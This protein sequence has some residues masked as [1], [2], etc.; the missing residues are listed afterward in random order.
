M[1]F[2]ITPPTAPA[3]PGQPGVAAAPG[4]AAD[5]FEA[6]LAEYAGAAGIQVSAQ[7]PAVSSNPAAAPAQVATEA[8]PATDEA[9]ASPNDQAAGTGVEPAQPWP[10]ITQPFA[11]APPVSAEAPADAL[12]G[13]VQTPPGLGKAA[14]R[15]EMLLAEAGASPP[16]GLQQ[17][18]AHLAEAG[19]PQGAAT[20]GEASEA[21]V[22]AAPTS[23]AQ[24]DADVRTA[25]PTAHAP[26]EPAS[27]AQPAVRAEPGQPGQPAVPA[28]PAIPAASAQVAQ[29]TRPASQAPS[30][31]LPVDAAPPPTASDASLVQPAPLDREAPAADP[32]APA[33]PAEPA[34]VAAQPLLQAAVVRARPIETAAAL[35]AAAE[36]T[37]PA[38]ELPTDDEPT[39][40]TPA[41]TPSQLPAAPGRRRASA[42]GETG[43]PK[44]EPAMTAAA[45]PTAADDPGPVHA[46]RS[47]PTT[48]ETAPPVQ[49]AAAAA[50]EALAAIDKPETPRA[51]EAAAGA[52]PGQASAEVPAQRDL[53]PGIR[54]A[55]DTVA[56][57]AADIARKLEG[58]STRFEVE[59]QPAGL[60]RVDVRIEIGA[61]GKLTAAFA[62]DSPQAAAE[63]RSRAPELQRALEQAGFDLSGGLSFDLADSSRF[64]RDPE[65]RQDGGAFRG[66]AFAQALATGEAADQAALPPKLSRR[67]SAA[68]DIRI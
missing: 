22:P 16:P 17:A 55:P 4:Q 34:P 48:A 45:S 33:K 28:T 40:A 31:S 68:L 6:L 66:R 46:A 30:R 12:A 3:S 25:R 13:Q 54:G 8:E 58:R 24:S 49:G 60:G 35:S 10:Q 2:S 47:A 50:P 7:T 37:E 20:P 64:G 32:A 21:L 63:L 57:L 65:A 51:P 43:Q 59:L 44:P 5:V 27:P 19:P 23:E 52:G 67:P 61:A 14:Q 53:A 1:A 26:A 41:P 18:A 29:A 56:A 62:V 36:P 15:I 38:A 42:T 11:P 9:P 39:L